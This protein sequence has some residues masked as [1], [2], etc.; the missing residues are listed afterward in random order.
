[1]NGIN[2]FIE[3][4]NLIKMALDETKKNYRPLD[5]GWYLYRKIQKYELENKF[6]KDFIELVFVTLFAW[7]MNSR[8][9]KL[10]EFI[11]FMDS[12]MNKKEIFLSLAE[13]T[14]FEIENQDVQKNLKDLF[15]SLDLVANSKPRLVTYSKALHFFLPELIGPIDRKYTMQF[16][17]GNTYVPNSIDRQFERFIDIELQYSKLA[18]STDLSKYKDDVWNNT[19]PKIVDNIIIGHLRINGRLRPRTMA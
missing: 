6:T 8:G 15:W 4:K 7:G 17:Y 13:K 2:Q 3:D 18:R 1:M 12:I 19:I 9:A 14:L 11:P 10:Q 16:F 5:P